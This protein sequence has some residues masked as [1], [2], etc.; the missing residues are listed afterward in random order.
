MATR[1]MEKKETIRADVLVIGAGFASGVIS[2]LFSSDKVAIIDG[3]HWTHR[4]T[5][6]AK[7]RY[8]PIAG[9]ASQWGGNLFF[10]IEDKNAGLGDLVRSV[11]EN[12]GLGKAGSFYENEFGFGYLLPK[13]YQIQPK[14]PTFS[15]LI[16]S[17]MRKRG[18]FLAYGTNYNYAAS[19]LVLLTGASSIMRLKDDEVFLEEIGENEV[20]DKFMTFELSEHDYGDLSMEAIGN[21]CYVARFKLRNS[22]FKPA[23]VP[24][25]LKLLHILN[26]Q[27]TLTKALDPGL[28]GLSSAAIKRLLGHEA[29]DFLYLTTVGLAESGKNTLQ[30]KGNA[31]DWV[32]PTLTDDAIN[33][34]KDLTISRALHSEVFQCADVISTL[35]SW[36]VSHD[37][38]SETDPGARFGSV[39]HKMAKALER[40]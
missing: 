14:H 7:K 13:K 12:H 25:L 10:D 39:G 37:Q 6:F 1:N 22:G 16:R 34:P 3:S 17:V 24:A 27:A 26:E 19:K 35:N 29:C 18:G 40:L 5:A 20:F 21:E 33:M 32:G 8:F 28:L 2:S 4:R 30:L 11:S 23:N 31:V 38:S 9:N 15:D 36:G